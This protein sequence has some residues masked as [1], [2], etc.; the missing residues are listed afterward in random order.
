MGIFSVSSTTGNKWSSFDCKGIV[1]VAFPFTSVTALSVDTVVLM[2]FIGKI[3]DV[4]VEGC[5]K[6][7]TTDPGG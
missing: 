7:S 5:D 1:T 6:D 4:L 2:V 3:A